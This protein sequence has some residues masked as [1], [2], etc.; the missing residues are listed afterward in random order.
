MTHAVWMF[1]DSVSRGVVLDGSGKYAPIRESFGVRACARLGLDLVNKS[2][3]GCTITKGMQIVSHVFSGAVS[4]ATTEARSG[5]A[6]S[7]LLEFG[8]NDCDFKWAEVAAAPESPHEPATPLD[9]FS[10]IY[11]DMVALL[12]S[13]CI[14]P[15][16][17]T[18]PP[19]DP[20]RY[21]AWFTRAGLD[22]GAILAWLGDVQQIYRWH[23][24]YSNA[25]W[26]VA[27]E[28]GCRVVDLREAFLRQRRYQDFLCE[29]G[30][31]PNESGHR[32]MAEVLFDA[33]PILCPSP[34]S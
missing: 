15:V 4:G 19:L 10:G 21:F 28:T 32:L 7:V 13:W 34:A 11:H 1:G 17:M 18:L 9:L 16:L 12:R 20:E 6:D 24:R 22:P 25:V 2:K 31:H 14:Q 30:I 5:R 33:S 3:F 8:G 26:R 27:T 23:E 29:D